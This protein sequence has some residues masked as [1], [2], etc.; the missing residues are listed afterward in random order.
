ML[1]LAPDAA[2]IY[3]RS[4][5]AA[6]SRRGYVGLQGLVYGATEAT[7]GPGFIRIDYL[8]V[9]IPPNVRAIAGA[10]VV[11]RPR[12]TAVRDE[13]FASTPETVRAVSASDGHFRASILISRPRRREF[14]VSVTAPGFEHLECAFRQEK[15]MHSAVVVL[16][17]RASQ[18]EA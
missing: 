3:V 14:I 2:G 17:R 6:L 10:E 5:W 7:S 16:M 13:R 15:A 9:A 8:D 1:S 18:A 4:A 12:P 11:I